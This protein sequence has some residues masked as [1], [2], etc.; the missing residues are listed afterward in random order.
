MLVTVFPILYTFLQWDF[1]LSHQEVKSIFPLPLI[2]VALGQLSLLAYG[3][4]D[5]V[6]VLGVALNWAGGFYFPPLEASHRGRSVGALR[7]LCSAKA[8][9]QGRR[10]GG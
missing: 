2:W 8:Q 9:A 4:S 6:P 5:T 3:R 10:P 1:P 7:P